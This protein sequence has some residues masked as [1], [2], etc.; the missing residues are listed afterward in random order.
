VEFWNYN[1]WDLTIQFGTICLILLFSN[2]LRRKIGF[3]RKSFLPTA[4]IGGFIAL[5]LRVGGLLNFIDIQVLNAITYHALNI[6]FIALALKRSYGT[7]KSKKGSSYKAG[8]TIVGT[9]LLQGVVGLA[10]TTFVGLIIMPSLFQAAG[11]LLPLGFGQGPGQA[12]NF[13]TIFETQNGF[14]GGQSFGLSIASLGFVVACLVCVIWINFRI[15]KK[16]LILRTEKSDLSA[17]ENINPSDEV[18]L[19]EAV[20]KFTL[21]IGIVMLVFMLSFLFMWGFDNLFISSNIL[22]T[23]GVKTVR[24]LLWGFNFIFGTLIAMLFKKVFVVLKKKGI[25]KREYCNNY[26][27]NRISG[28]VFD[29]MIIASIALI[30]PVLLSSTW[31]VL[32]IVCGVGAISTFFYLQFVCKKQFP[33]YW[34]ESFMCLYG[35]LTGTAS[36]GIAL[37]RVV[38]PNFETPASTDLVSGS[39]VA[40]IF[41]FPLM[42]LIGLAPSMPWLTLVLLAVF[43]A[44]INFLLFYKKKK[45][46]KTN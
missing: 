12:N 7:E 34:V 21:Q 24:P 36:T 10:I 26:I 5:G 22:G 23:F 31:W 8:L 41:G 29:F 1:I 46:Q 27:L 13:G 33:D 15:K 17:S 35:N 11:I 39:A 3:L 14:V 43:S 38:D 28:S 25:A 18:P 40:V 19:S 16:G 32:L 42:L 45:K 6:G 2:I 9:Y 37:L 4:V 44:F 30:D 20:D